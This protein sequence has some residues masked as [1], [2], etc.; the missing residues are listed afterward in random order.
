M[1][2]ATTVPSTL[3][4]AITRLV[5]RGTHSMP[6]PRRTEQ[7]SSASTSL[8]ATSTTTQSSGR[9]IVN[10]QPQPSQQRH[11]RPRHLE[12]EEPPLLGMRG[13]EGEQHRSD[14]VER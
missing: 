8:P 2:C 9:V 12:S 11:N 1:A 13:E 14:E 7:S 10:P 4:E 3:T 5:C 6:P